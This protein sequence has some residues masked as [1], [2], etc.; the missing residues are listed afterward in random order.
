[1]RPWARVLL[2]VLLVVAALVLWAA[3]MIRF[4]PLAVLASASRLGLRLE[5]LRPAAVASAIGPQRVFVGGEGPTLVLLHGSGDN[6]GTWVRV[7]PA[8][9]PGRRLVIPDLAGHGD[10]APASGPIAVPTI[11]E[12][13]EAI[14]A[15]LAAGQRV[16]LVGNSLGAWVAML[17]AHRHLEWVERV[18]AVD[19]GALTGHR[20][21]KLLPS[22]RQDARALVSLLRDPASP[23][24]PDFLLDDLVRQSRTGPLA[25]LAATAA[26]MEQQ[27]LDGRL[28]ELRLP[29]DLVWGASDRLMPLEYANRM[30]A[31]LPDARLIVIPACGHAPQLECPET[32]VTALRRALAERE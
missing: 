4:R 20:A 1:M 30:M 18:V 22:N 9:L 11:V 28:G 27:T 24:V 23:P 2:A 6:A 14:L 17:V 31:E 3:W 25:R 19:G 8:L 10:S 29:V 26:T 5:G 32:F 15:K 16:T 21:V 12:G 13:V 7:V